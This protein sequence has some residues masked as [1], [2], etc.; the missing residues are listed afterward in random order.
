MFS[1]YRPV[2]T[3]A[4]VALLSLGVGCKKQPSG[5]TWLKTMEEGK[6]EATKEKKPLLVYY[7]ADGVEPCEEFETTVL[8]DPGVQAKMEGYV[9]VKIDSDVDEETPGRYGV[10][11]Y[12]TTIFYTAQGEEV[13]RV[14][15]N[16]PPPQFGQLLEDIRNGKVEPV[17]ALL[18]REETNPNDVKLAYEVGTMYVETGRPEKAVERF[19]RVLAQDPSNASG[20]LPGATLQLGFADMMVQNYDEAAQYFETVVKTY[21]TSPEA[22]K[23]ALYLGDLEQLKGDPEAAVAAYGRL[24]ETYPNAPEAKEAEAKIGKLSMFEDTVKTFTEGKPPR[25]EG[26]K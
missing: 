1:P 19:K 4:A 11:I 5:P 3:L 6:K 23:A 8:G 15:G 14:V 16:V 20:L 17:A 25:G 24:L 13:K 9:L 2:L 10:K 7:S 18:R 21:P 12:P 22:P 26:K